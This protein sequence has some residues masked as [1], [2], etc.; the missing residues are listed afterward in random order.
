MYDALLLRYGEIGIKKGNRHFFENQLLNN[1]RAAIA[2]LGERKVEKTYG[3]MYVELFDDAD[4]VIP[5]IQQVFGIVG[6]S[7]AKHVE[8]NLAAIQQAALQ[9][10]D[11]AIAGREIVTFK[12]EAKRPYKRFPMES[13]ELASTVGGYLLSARPDR[14]KVDVHQPEVTVHVEVRQEGAYVYAQDIPGIGGLP[15]G[16][17]GRGVLLLS[18]GI[19]SPVAGWMAMKRGVAI[20]AVYFHSFPF[21]T[22][23]AKEKVLD[24]ARVLARYCG[25]VDVHIVHF[26]DLQKAIYQNCPPRL[27][28]TIMRRMMLRLA[29]RVARKEGAL[30]LFTG[31]SVGQV[32]SQTL[33]SI[34]VTNAVASLPV[35]RPL[36]AMDKRD[37][38]EIAR[39]IG[40]YEIS[41]LPYEDCCTLFVPKHPETKPRLIDAERAE[42]SFDFTSLLDDAMAKTEV[43]RVR[44]NR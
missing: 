2:D 8:L 43:V 22:D 17:S 27:G 11:D 20:S 19:D 33:Q 36:I 38:V 23:R 10:L 35:L 4:Q 7:P 30:A 18:G 31:E 12:V 40:T 25:S 24:L 41:I 28:V 39:Q 1:I 3:R 21:T 32:A 9:V 26:T 29:E 42:A 13:P 5:R 16:S 6:I 15:V 37:I 44:P 14:V 34:A